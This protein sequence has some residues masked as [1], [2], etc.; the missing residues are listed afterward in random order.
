[1]SDRPPRSHRTEADIAE[2]L[3]QFDRWFWPPEVRSQPNVVPAFARSLPPLLEWA[4]ANLSRVGDHRFVAEAE[5]DGRTLCFVECGGAFN[6]YI[7][8]EDRSSNPLVSFDVDDQ[9]PVLL[10]DLIVGAFFERF[11]FDSIDLRPSDFL[12]SDD[13]LVWTGPYLGVTDPI[14][15]WVDNDRVV[16]DYWS[17]LSRLLTVTRPVLNVSGE[18]DSISLAVPDAPHLPHVFLRRGVAVE[19]TTFRPRPPSSPMDSGSAAWTDIYRIQA[20]MLGFEPTG[21]VSIPWSQLEPHWLAITQ[22]LE[23]AYGVPSDH[24][25]HLTRVGSDLGYDC[26]VGNTEALEQLRV[27]LQTASRA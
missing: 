6:G 20:E 26:I 1:M 9:S 15:V 12:P 4:R 19:L 10:T 11:C 16:L 27:L 3:D 18:I 7:D 13:H 14:R 23:P 21:T 22:D 5:P 24:S 8:P 25:V 2:K 17:D